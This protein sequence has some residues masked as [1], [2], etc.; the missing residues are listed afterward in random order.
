MP[1]TGARVPMQV[2]PQSKY[3]EP[4]A[5]A[6]R[7][8]LVEAQIVC[9]G[10]YAF[11]YPGVTLLDSSFLCANLGRSLSQACMDKYSF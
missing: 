4:G 1:S 11:W 8:V 3:F 10:F 2:R 6:N 9:D 5:C 7:P